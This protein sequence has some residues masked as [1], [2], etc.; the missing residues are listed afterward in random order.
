MRFYVMLGFVL[1]AAVPPARADVIM[2][3]VARGECGCA[4]GSTPEEDCTCVEN[5]PRC[6]LGDNSCPEGT[7]CDSVALCVE[8]QD[9]CQGYECECWTEA[10]ASGACIFESR[11]VANPIPETGHGGGGGRMPA[12]TG[13]GCRNDPELASAVPLVATVLLFLGVRRTPR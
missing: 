1:L 12:S 13:C 5:P 4:I 6:E 10:C 7:V 3:G 2:P 8:N 11:C 9:D